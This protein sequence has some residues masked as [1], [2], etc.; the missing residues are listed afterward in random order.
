MSIDNYIKTFLP[1]EDVRFDSNGRPIIIG[2]LAEYIVATLPLQIPSISVFCEINTEG[3]QLGKFEFS[4][5]TPT[6]E[7]IHQ[8]K[9]SV[10]VGDW[11]KPAP[12]AFKF[13]ATTFSQEGIYRFYARIDEDGSE[14][15]QI[16]FFNIS[17]VSSPME[18]PNLKEFEEAMQNF[19][20][21]YLKKNRF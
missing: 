12:F 17:K 7:K 11:K 16:R 20:Q 1:S 21:E 3:K 14:W 18:M 4:L 2:V 5:V 10:T 13:P 9:V 19:A 15:K 8:V 6:G